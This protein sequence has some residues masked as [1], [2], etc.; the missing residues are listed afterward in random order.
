MKHTLLD[1]ALILLG[2]FFSVTSGNDVYMLYAIAL[3]LSYHLGAI[4]KIV[5]AILEEDDIQ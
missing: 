2:L 3:M 1:T 5:D 4:H